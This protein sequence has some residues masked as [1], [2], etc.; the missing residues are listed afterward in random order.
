LDVNN[1]IHHGELSEEVYMQLPPGFAVQG[2]NMADFCLF[3][4]ITDIDFTALLIYVDD[5]IVASSNMSCISA[6]KSFLDEKFKIKDL[7]SLRYFLGLE[8]AS[9]LKGISLCQRK[10]ALDILQDLGLLGCKLVDFKYV[11]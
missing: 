2:A 10:Y 1:A 5:I 6:F 7:G 8:V 11:L 9:S 3:T 4:I